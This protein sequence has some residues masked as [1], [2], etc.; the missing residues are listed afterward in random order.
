MLQSYWSKGTAER[1]SLDGRESNVKFKDKSIIGKAC[2]K[3][4]L[5]IDVHAK[6][7]WPS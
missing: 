5:T 4:G 1:M 6:G 3:P 7:L 2:R